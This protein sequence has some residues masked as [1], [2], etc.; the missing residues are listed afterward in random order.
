MVHMIRFHDGRA[1]YRNRFVRTVGLAAEQEA[2]QR[3]V[4][5][6]G[7]AAGAVAAP[8]RL[9]GARA[10][11]GRLQHRRRR[12]RRARADQLL[13]VRR[14]LRARPA[15][16]GDARARDLGRPL[17]RP[18]RRLGPHQ[19]RRAH[20]RAAVL[21]LR[22]HARRTCTT[23]SSTPPNELVHYVDIPLP[24][25]R[26]PHD[27]AFTEHYAIL[28]DCPLFWDPEAM[29]KGIYA[30]RFH[31]DLPT[32]FA[33]IPRRGA[34][35]RRALVRGRADLRAALDQRLRGRRRDRARRLLPARPGAGAARAPAATTSACSTTWRSTR[36]ARARIAGASTWP[37]GRRREEDLSDRIME[38]G[39][40]NGRH[41]GPPLP[42]RLQHDRQAR[43][44]SC[45]TAWSSTTS[46]TGREQRYAFGD[47]VYGSETPMA[48]RPGAQRRG[49]RLPGH[50]RHRHERRPLG[51]PGLRRRRHHRRPDRPGAP[52]GAH[53]QRHALVLGVAA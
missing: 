32:R 41:G 31:P 50:V 39:M 53:Q 28:N 14:P 19:G 48:P 18:T 6:P 35:Q 21:Q 43:A 34:E 51:V 42:L 17:S 7:R 36:W 15:H 38:F 3:A 29:A 12:P 27:M 40:I 49:R 25:P 44:G 1:E 47:G 45:S 37:P 10:H 16:A 46:Q 20:R 11:E 5:G 23:A 33:V 2:G 8:R 13:P 52:A 22:H 26:L 30:A 9:G 4:G 24:G